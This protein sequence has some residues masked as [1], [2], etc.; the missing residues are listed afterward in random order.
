MASTLSS[1]WS[2]NSTT[3]P[4]LS[5][6]RTRRLQVVKAQSF[7]DEGRSMNIVDANLSVLK[8]RIEGVKMK[9]RLERCRSK[10]YYGWYYQTGYVDYKHKRDKKHVISPELL[11]L[12]GLIGGS[13]G[14]PIVFGSLLL[15]IVSLAV[16]NT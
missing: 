2:S 15:C 11:N 7:R 3:W 6:S 14:F 16:H 1:C 13:I 10:E 4:Q 12:V 5:S 8:E 9:E